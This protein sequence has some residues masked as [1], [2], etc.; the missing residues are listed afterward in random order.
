MNANVCKHNQFIP[1]ALKKK[2]FVWL[3]PST[4]SVTQEPADGSV[5]KIWSLI[6]LQNAVQVDELI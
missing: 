4:A 1:S 3:L 2:S 6:R 5:V